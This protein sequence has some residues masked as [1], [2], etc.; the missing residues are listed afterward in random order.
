MYVLSIRIANT[1]QRAYDISTPLIWKEVE[2]KDRKTQ[3]EEANDNH[4]DTPL[5]R[6]L[7]IFVK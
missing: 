3:R 7:L 6:K 2:L 1:F 5:L 4:D